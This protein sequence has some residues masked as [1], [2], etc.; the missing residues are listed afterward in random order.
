MG[1]W[2]SEHRRGDNVRHVALAAVAR[3]LRD[4]GNRR[5]NGETR[6]DVA[7]AAVARVLSVRRP[8]EL[9][10]KRRQA[11]AQEYGVEI[12]IHIWMFG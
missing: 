8:G 7:L 6:C 9:T 4:L 3:V 11:A 2:R 1:D 5:I 12:H 10:H